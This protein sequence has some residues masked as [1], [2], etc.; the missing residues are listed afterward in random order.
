MS[1]KM[2]KLVTVPA[3]G[4]ISIG[5]TWAGRQILIEEMNTAEIRISAGSFVLDGGAD[6]PVNPSSSNPLFAKIKKDSKSKK[7]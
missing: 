6:T 1:S 5:K 7:K 2:A 3:N 4:Q